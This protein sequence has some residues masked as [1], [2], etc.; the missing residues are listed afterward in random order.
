MTR[1]RPARAADASAIAT[2]HVACWRSAYAGLLDAAY[3]A[4]LS[5]GRQ[6][7]FQR[8]H[9]VR[10]GAVFVAETGGRVV[11]YATAGRS[12]QPAIAEG[13]IE[14]LYVLDDYRERGLGRA[15]MQA[16]AARLQAAGCADL[17]LWVL[18]ANP[19]RWFYEHLGGR[20]VRRGATLVAGRPVMQVAYRW[21]DLRQLLG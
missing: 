2:V 6:A 9:I 4:G 20:A 11:G 14:T 3:L 19:S 7:A 13:E 21:A 1:V 10:G 5:E 16:A 17:W 12:R 18:E 8:A 15:L